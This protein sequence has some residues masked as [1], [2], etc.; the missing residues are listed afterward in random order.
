M[1][2]ADLILKIYL[3]VVA[4]DVGLGWVQP[5]PTRPP[6]RFTHLLTEPPQAIIRRLILPRWTWGWDFSPVILV[7]L[8][9]VLRVSFLNP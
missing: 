4:V 9:G 3:V 5:D 7:V 1:H 6:R 2:T 8:L